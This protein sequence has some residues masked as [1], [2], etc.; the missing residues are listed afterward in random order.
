MQLCR[1]SQAKDKN[2][3]RLYKYGQEGLQT[4]KY[5]YFTY[6][7]VADDSHIHNIHICESKLS[8]SHISKSAILVS[9]LLLLLFTILLS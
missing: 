7:S 6:L 4:K 3:F 9:I 5:P 8:L 2:T 1:N